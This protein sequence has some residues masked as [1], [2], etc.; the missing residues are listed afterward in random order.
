MVEDTKCLLI[1]HRGCGYTDFN[2]NTIRA[3]QKVIDEGISAIE[4]DV[5]L[6]ADKLPIVVHNLDLSE[7][8][9]G[10]GPVFRTNWSEISKLYAGDPERGKDRIPEL[11]EVLEWFAAIPA[12]SRAVMHLELKGAGSGELCGKLVRQWL[13]SRKL[14]AENFLIS[15]FNWQE[16]QDLKEHCSELQIALLS[17]GIR[18]DKLLRR[19]P[20]GPEKLH[21][22]FAYPAEDYIFPKKSSYEE[23][24][25]MIDKVYSDPQER[26]ILYEIVQRAMDGSFYDE[27]LLEA[28]EEMGAV[29]INLWYRSL[30]EDFM[31]KAQQRGLLV[32]IYTI[33]DMDQLVKWARAGVDGIF[34]DVYRDAKVALAR[35]S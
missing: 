9:T 3:F 19:L 11:R 28:A 10:S 34:T 23:N 30:S 26:E 18:R 29:A 22:I 6:T 24:K 17:G 25:V 32:N 4:F 7:V 12:T 31:R 5:Q 8:S 20:C 13:D 21:E 27:M 2:Q 1:G 14:S 15:S 16:L 33:N 35:M